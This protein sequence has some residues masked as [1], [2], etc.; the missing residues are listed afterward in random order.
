[1]FTEEL[2]LINGMDA[3]KSKEAKPSVLPSQVS[4][5]ALLASGGHISSTLQEF[6]Y[7]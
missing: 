4:R 2:E 6:Y 1:M 5:E 7:Y 3:S